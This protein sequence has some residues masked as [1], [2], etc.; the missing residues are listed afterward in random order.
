MSSHRVFF[1]AAEDA[2]IIK[3][4]K[5]KPDAPWSAIAKRIKGKTAK[6]CNDRY[7][8]HLKQAK[9]TSPWTEEEDERL[10]KLASEN[11]HNWV[12]VS[13]LMGTRS[14][15]ESKNRW[16]VLERMHKNGKKSIEPIKITKNNFQAATPQPSIPENNSIFAP[17]KPKNTESEEKATEAQ[18]YNFGD[19][20]SV[21]IDQFFN[22]ADDVLEQDNEWDNIFML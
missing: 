17:A 22:I 6:Q 15:I 11:G 18:F 21:D 1:T 9:N 19:F 5:K 12:I 13:K 3:L 16:T 14:N 2:L 20:D 4:R 8:K 10:L 7:N